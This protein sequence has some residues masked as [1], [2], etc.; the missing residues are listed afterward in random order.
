MNKIFN[1]IIIL[2]IF[3]AGWI[4][5]FIGT[6]EYKLI[7]II[8]IIATAF[9][10]LFYLQGLMIYSKTLINRTDDTLKTFR[11]DLTNLVHR[12]FTIQ[13]TG[14]NALNYNKPV[15]YIANHLP[16]SVIDWVPLILPGHS[17]TKIVSVYQ[18]NYGLINTITQA[19]GSVPVKHNGG[20]QQFINSCTE[21][22]NNGYSL[23]IYAEGKHSHKKKHWSLLE[24]FQTG[25]FH[26]AVKTKTSIVPVIT[27]GFREHYGL[28]IPGIL[29]VHH[30]DAIESE[31]RNVEELRDL[32]QKIMRERMITLTD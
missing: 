19:F 3:I 30:L 13:S 11:T 27:E 12:Y 31:K 17:K 25:V 10:S 32:T 9:T 4:L 18:K 8:L 6:S 28:I 23:F 2:I 7:G 20:Y 21:E 1:I 14:A 16:D 29:K 22:I 15:I 5:I 26:L 24:T